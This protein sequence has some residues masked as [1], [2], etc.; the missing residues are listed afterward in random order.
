MLGVGIY[1]HANLW[2]D[3]QI[4]SGGLTR[5]RIWT[6]IF[7]PYWQIYGEANLETLTGTDFFSRYFSFLEFIRWF[8]AGLW[9][10]TCKW[11]VFI[12]NST[13]S[14]VNKTP[15]SVSVEASAI[16]NNL[17]ENHVLSKLVAFCLQRERERA[18][19]N[20][21]ICI[22]THQNSPAFS[23]VVLFISSPKLDVQVSF[24][25]CLLTLYLYLYPSVFTIC[26]IIIFFWRNNGSSYFTQKLRIT[27]G[28]S[29]YWC[30]ILGKFKVSGKVQNSCPVH[31]FL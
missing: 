3:H 27:L 26:L 29:W 8:L 6:I 16:P 7:Y 30:V 28:V 17:T 25:D 23:N 13:T 11:Q 4:W 18:S 1:Y 19:V 24:S 10:K 31:L 20:I 9:W 22:I 14:N 5:W 21:T 2:P 12:I 15:N